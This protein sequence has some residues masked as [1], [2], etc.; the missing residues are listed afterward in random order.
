MG[1][2]LSSVT[3][4]FAA[5]LCAFMMLNV[6]CFFF[7]LSAITYPSSNRATEHIWKP[8]TLYHIAE[9]GFG[10]GQIDKL[11]YNNYQD[12][13]TLD[14]IIMGS[15]H[16]SGMYT[17]MMD[18][19]PILLNEL[20][21]GRLYFYNLGMNSHPFLLCVR[22]TRNAIATFQPRRYLIME[23]FNIE[24]DY[25]FMNAVINGTY[26]HAKIHYPAGIKKFLQHFPTFRRLY[27]QW[28]WVNQNELEN[29][30]MGGGIK[31]I[32]P[33]EYNS[34]LSDV[35]EMLVRSTNGQEIIIFFHPS[36]DF[37]NAG[38]MIPVVN[39]DKLRDFARLCDEHGITFV[40]MTNDFIAAYDKERIVPYGFANTIP[41]R[42][43]LNKYGHKM[44]AER[45][46]R[47]IEAIEQLE[48]K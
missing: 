36:I 46:Y 5:L 7:Y 14:G 11:G 31:P 30:P 12:K 38:N 1:K 41:G 18:N 47:T 2:R 19:S 13:G 4:V 32:D 23:T 10:R 33:S 15:S 26:P 24:F 29:P 6:F 45:L 22:N 34:A 48:G 27:A 39:Q 28:Q 25:D 40:D 21:K 17:D 44:I 8:N 42:G 37:D 16:M 20:Y 43:H 9:E 3:K 35:L